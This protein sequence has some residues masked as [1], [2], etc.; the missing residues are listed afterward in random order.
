MYLSLSLAVRKTLK[1]VNAWQ[2]YRQKGWLSCV[3]CSPCND[4]A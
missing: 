4:P 3:S 2:S 1:L